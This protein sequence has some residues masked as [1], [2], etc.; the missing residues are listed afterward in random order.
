MSGQS[1]QLN[2]H[3]HEGMNHLIAVALKEWK[4]SIDIRPKYPID[5]PIFFQNEYSTVPKNQGTFKLKGSNNEIYY[6]YP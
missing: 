5:I 6:Y 1:A 4:C 3:P 2:T